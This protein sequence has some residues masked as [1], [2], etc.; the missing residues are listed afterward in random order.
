MKRVR[1]PDGGNVTWIMRLQRS[2]AE[3]DNTSEK[4]TGCPKRSYSRRQLR[5]S[6]LNANSLVFRARSPLDGNWFNLSARNESLN[7]HC[8]VFCGLLHCHSATQTK[9]TSSKYC[10]TS[11]S[12]TAAC[13][14]QL[15]TSKSIR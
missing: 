6:G 1:L 14:P 12:K 13:L 3:P 9:S 5:D 7:H 4:A 2:K 10:S 11:G 15:S 8:V